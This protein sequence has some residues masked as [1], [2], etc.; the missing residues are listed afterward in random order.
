MWI[1]A[2]LAVLV[3]APGLA[4]TDYYVSLTGSD[5]GTGTAANPWRTVQ[6]ALDNTGN[7]T[8]ANWTI[9]NV[10]PGRFAESWNTVEGQLRFN[11][12]AY[13][14]IQ[15]AG[16]MSVGGTQIGTTDGVTTYTKVA[17]H[18]GVLL[19][20]NSTDVEIK[21]LIIGEDRA[22]DGDLG[23]WAC[24][25][26]AK[27]TTNITLERVHIS[28]P[29]KATMIAAGRL[30]SHT[31]VD[32]QHAA[33]VINLQNVLITGHGSYLTNPEGEVHAKRVTFAKFCGLGWDSFFTFVQ[34][35]GSL[36]D[37]RL[38]TLEDCIFY[39][40]EGP[41]SGRRVKIGYG[42]GGEDNMYF[43]A[44][45]T[46]GD[47]NIVVRAMFDDAVPEYWDD[48]VPA[49]DLTNA[50]LFS[51]VTATTIMKAHGV[52]VND[53]TTL[54]RTGN[55]VIDNTINLST[56]NDFLY[57]SPQG[58][59]SGWMTYISGW[60]GDVDRNGV[61]DGLDLTAVLTAWE[62]IPGD[63]LW[64]PDADLDGNNVVN[65]LDLTEVI[66]NWTVASAAA[67]PE[68]GSSEAATSDTTTKRGP[69]NVSRGKDNV[70]RKK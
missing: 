60:A 48:A 46:G 25:V 59:D 15:G 49:R 1:I 45:S 5:G 12:K 53:D 52:F 67:A 2:G 21:D 10:G 9:I 44:S 6:H 66:S 19:V 36:V 37:N 33:S 62:T 43:D 29:L 18:W 70:K 8:G 22:W 65:G 13:V 51:R 20:D 39:E 28:G 30:K 16:A 68:A 57:V 69:G 56:Y 26:W 17:G 3:A 4:D 58:L 34:T 27:H 40:L 11:N 63:L 61:V 50:F 64:N 23:V 7:G 38:Y 55:L 47:E 32:A 24:T 54:A 14:R 31:A 41:R 42:H 35:P